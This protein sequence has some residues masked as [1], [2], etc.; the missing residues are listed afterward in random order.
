MQ[1]QESFACSE[2][3]LERYGELKKGDAKG[4]LGGQYVLSE[5]V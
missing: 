1:C 4:V 3:A 2:Q 5:N